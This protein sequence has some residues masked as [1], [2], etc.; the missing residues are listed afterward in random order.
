MTIIAAD[1]HYIVVGL[2]ATGLS[3]VRYLVSRGKKVSVVD[4][5]LTPP[6]AAMLKSEYSSVECFFG[7]FDP[8]VLSAAQ[9][10][11]MSPGV[12]LSTPAIQQAIQAGVKVTSDIELFLNEFE[13]DVIAITGSNAKSTVTSWLGE[14]L[15]QDS[16]KALVAGNIG[17]PVLSTLD[18]HYDISV[19]ELSSFQ[20][21]LLSN[22]N[23]TVATVLNVSEDHMDRYETFADYQ[24]AKQRI[25]FGCKR[26]VF[27]RDDILTQPLIPDS[28]PRSTFGDSRPDISQYGILEDQGELWLAKGF[29]KI[30]QASEVSLKGKHNLLNALSVLALADAVGNER[31]HTLNALKNFQ[32]LPY[33]CQFVDTVNEVAFF[34][35]SKATNVGSTLAAVLGLAHEYQG[36]VIVLLGGQGK[37]QDFSPLSEAVSKHCKASVV[38]GEDR[39]E[40]LKALPLSKELPELASAFYAAVETAEKGDVILLSPACASFDEFKS[41]EHRGH[42]F[43]ELVEAQR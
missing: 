30:L 10:L 7:E 17:V 43:N 8:Q 29:E 23:A 34:N 33:R 36:R 6:N 13:G 28:T 2:G 39:A 3:C 12:A 20:L 40:L 11:V 18:E 4:S 25:Y 31:S 22:L 15:N 26:A 32:G 21:E 16:K 42:V 5:R 38:Y 9:V 27:N 41:F 14:A 35:D 1:T 19:L 37:G 24:Q